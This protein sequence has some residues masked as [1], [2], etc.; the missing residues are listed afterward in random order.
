VFARPVVVG[1]VF[2]RPVVVVTKAVATAQG[3]VLAASNVWEFLQ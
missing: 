2:A 3:V 1:L